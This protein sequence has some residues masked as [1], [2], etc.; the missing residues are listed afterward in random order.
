VE[1]QGTVSVKGTIEGYGKNELVVSTS[2]IVIDDFGSCVLIP[3]KIEVR[4]NY[5]GT[6]DENY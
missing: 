3:T 1:V 4:V 2:Q 6:I 5:N